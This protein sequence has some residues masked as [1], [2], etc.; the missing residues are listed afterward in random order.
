VAAQLQCVAWRDEALEAGARVVGQLADVDPLADDVPVHAQELEGLGQPLREID[1]FLQP[2]RARVGG[3]VLQRQPFFHQAP[4]GVVQVARVRSEAAAVDLDEAHRAADDVELVVGRQRSLRA[5]RAGLADQHLLGDH[6][7]GQAA[8]AP[9]AAEAA[10]VGGQPAAQVLAQ[11]AQVGVDARPQEPHLTAADGGLDHAGARQGLERHRVGAVP[12][13]DQPNQ[14]LLAQHPGH[15]LAGSELV[16][17]N[18]QQRR[19]AAQ[20]VGVDVLVEAARVGVVGP[21]VE[22]EQVAQ[23]QVLAVRQQPADA[24]R[25]QQVRPP[26]ACQPP[27]EVPRPRKAGR[28]WRRAPGRVGRLGAGWIEGRRMRVHGAFGP[29]VAGGA[30][31][32]AGVRPLAGWRPGW[33]VNV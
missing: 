9:L 6:P 3:V 25:H 23:R 16:G 10:E 8:V 12:R 20:H 24:P 11:F 2:R 7:V 14:V 19:A 22:V 33:R 15:V 21:A 29:G 13:A 4:V 30:V 5:L 17:R 31:R 18:V 26:D 28:R 32:L 1:H 27:Q